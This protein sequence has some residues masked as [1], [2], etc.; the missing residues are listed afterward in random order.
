MTN[1]EKYKDTILEIVRETGAYPALKNGVPVRCRDILGCEGCDLKA[2]S[3]R[4]GFFEWLYEDD[5]EQ[6][7][8]CNS[9]KHA[10]KDED[11][12]PCSECSRNYTDMFE[13]KTEKTRQS[14]LLKLFPNATVTEGLLEIPPCVIEG[15]GFKERNCESYGYCV[16][17]R[18]DYWL[19][20]VK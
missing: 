9:C 3:C 2:M 20:E 11:E 18:K 4:T 19:K 1:F 17:C 16:D 8:T 10:D 6:E 13:L 5:G 7:L 14:E 15:R 12:Y